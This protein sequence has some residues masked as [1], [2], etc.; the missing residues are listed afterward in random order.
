MELVASDDLMKKLL[1]DEIYRVC[2]ATM[3]APW[4]ADW[5][6]YDE[7]ILVCKGCRRDTANLECSLNA[8]KDAMVHLK[9]ATDF[10]TFYMRRAIETS[11]VEQQIDN[12][13]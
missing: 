11:R 2:D 6:K 7:L 4:N 10:E 1:R 13:L 3:S 8:A 12:H 5:K 9:Y